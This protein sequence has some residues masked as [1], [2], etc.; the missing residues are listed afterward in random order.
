MKYI[1]S[2][3]LLKLTHE[4][5]TP[6]QIHELLACVGIEC[7]DAKAEKVVNEC[8]GKDVATVRKYH[9]YCSGKQILGVE[10]GVK[11]QMTRAPT[12]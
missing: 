4:E 1:A 2:F 11:R 8:K 5:V 10:V 9:N 12:A 6:K 3:L 7:D